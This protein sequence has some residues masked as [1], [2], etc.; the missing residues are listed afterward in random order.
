MSKYLSQHRFSAA[1]LPASVVVFVVVIASFLTSQTCYACTSSSVKSFVTFTDHWTDE[2][3]EATDGCSAFIYGLTCNLDDNE[4]GTNASTVAPTTVPTAPIS[5]AISEQILTATCQWQD[6]KANENENYWFQYWAGH[7]GH[8]L[9]R[10]KKDVQLTM[11]LAEKLTK[12]TYQFPVE[13]SKAYQ[14]GVFHKKNN[15]EI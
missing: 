5:E 11:I 6:I 4:A 3:S 9:C 14:V 1:P 8:Q 7:C 10:E 2:Q 15:L 13:K 12:T